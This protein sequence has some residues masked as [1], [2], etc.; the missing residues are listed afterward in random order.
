MAESN[1]TA[2]VSL[3]GRELE[4]K[5][6]ADLVSGVR[7]RGGALFFY[8]DAGIGKSALLGYAGGLAQEAGLRVLRA[9]GAEV[10][11]HLPLAGLH[12]IL[13]PLRGG[14]EG[15]PGPQRDALQGALGLADS[16][17]PDLYLVGLAVLNLLAEA[18]AE[19]PLLLLAED[20]QWLDQA[21][22]DVLAFVARRLESEPIVLVAAGRDQA[23][24]QLMSAGLPTVVVGPLGE[25]AAAELLDSVAPGLDQTAR[26]RLLGESAGNPLALIEL[27]GSV[28]D[29][30]LL[31]ATLP[32]SARLEQAFGARVAALPEATRVCLLVASLNDS[33]SVAEVLAAASAIRGEVVEAE[34]L[35]AAVGAGLIELQSRTVNFRHPLMRS[36]ISQ[37]AGPAEHEAAQRALA[38]VLAD[39]PDRQTWHLAAAACGPDENIAAQLVD[40]ADQAQRRGS[41]VVAIEALEQAAQLSESPQKKADRVLRAA[42]LASEYGD[43]DLVRRLLAEVAAAE[44]SP[45]Q[46]ARATW[47]RSSFDDG[48]SEDT[49]GPIELARLAES[50]A[51]DGDFDLAMK[52][53]WGA[54]MRCFWT[55]PGAEARQVLMD[56]ADGM[57]LDERDPRLLAISAYVAPIERGKSV[58]A[59]LMDLAGATGGDPQVE[60]FLG[61]AAMQIG[62]FELS[63][64]FSSAAAAGLRPQGRLGL[65]AR[66]LAV[67]AWS[68]ARLGNLAV[69][70]PSAEEG[71][72]LAQETNQ[73]FMY[74][75]AK[76]V[77][78]EIA[79]LRGDYA[80]ATELA[81]EAEQVGIAAG[82]RPVLATVQLARGLVALG[83]G[84][85]ADAFA[86]LCRIHDPADPAYQVALRC[87]VVGDLAE[88]AVRG[89]QV[90]GLREIVRELE[91]FAPST[92]SPALHIGLRYASALLAE[93]DEAE[94]LFQAALAAELT[95]WPL[96]RGRIQLAYGEWLR[97]QRRTADSRAH[98]RAARETFDAL[99]VIAGSERARSELRA[100]GE[101]SP[102]R[103]PDAREQLTP[104]ELSIAQLAA[105][106]LT[107]R[108]IGQR[109]YLSHR[110]VS[111]HLHRIFPKLGITSR[112]DLG[113]VLGPVPQ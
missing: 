40:V 16:A 44:L 90:E 8:G 23:S 107:N 19:T 41:V 18:A 74:G 7:N 1:R 88:A 67:N 69:A 6:L 34:V 80:A 21:S 33:D 51:A 70:L 28:D 64:R 39:Q 102:R 22:A 113:A 109:L 31:K 43:R 12:Q 82:A 26:D 24:G 85:Y 61:S 5:L 38:E 77:Q 100:A 97:R 94:E 91:S 36:A 11:Q 78:A 32:L 86:D 96:E 25:G 76:A 65:V 106:G 93:G 79:A 30:S 101:T 60:R 72:R 89:G 13:Y 27:P 75:L 55:E 103:T 49:A 104:H 9:A 81:A 48:L 58:A 42:D 14:V 17:V 15:L 99:G 112:A 54:G 37:A 84:R 46:A 59:G 92:T 29:Q 10:E 4:V 108:E 3:V 98:L 105:D 111:T 73:P 35:S 47:I 63:T 52:I 53:L 57:P 83:E 110:T 45:Q 68:A 2:R 20:V 71:A 95:G 87:Y 62:G 56:V 50:V 66:A